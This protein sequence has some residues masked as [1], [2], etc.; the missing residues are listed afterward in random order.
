MHPWDNYTA[1]EKAVIEREVEALSN[2]WNAHM[3]EVGDSN[4]PYGVHP[5]P[6]IFALYHTLLTSHHSSPAVF[7][8]EFAD[9]EDSERWEHFIEETM[10]R[11][12]AYGDVMFR[13]GQWCVSRGLLHANL[14]PCK[15]ASV[16]DDML[17][18][19]LEGPDAATG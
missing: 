1:D 12:V 19:L 13:F 15:C 11:V 8:A 18:Q 14:I 5:P 2:L 4:I 10:G 6:S 9:S 7:M 16:T 17:S 3:Q